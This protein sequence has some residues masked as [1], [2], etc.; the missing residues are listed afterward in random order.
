M[1]LCLYLII[2]YFMV[3]FVPVPNSFSDCVLYEDNSV[4]QKVVAFEKGPIHQI[5]DNR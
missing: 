2:F 4:W 1:I 3:V 5:K